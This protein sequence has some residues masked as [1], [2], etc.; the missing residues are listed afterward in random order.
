MT[1]AAAGFPLASAITR[2]E[3]SFAAH[4]ARFEVVAFT[5]KGINRRSQGDAFLVNAEHGLLAVADGVS[6]LPNG[7]LTA[8]RCLRWLNLALAAAKPLDAAAIR[9]SVEA[10]NRQ[11]FAATIRKQSVEL[12]GGCI[13]VGLTLWPDGD[14]L[15]YFHV[16]DGALLHR[17]AATGSF[18]AVTQPHVSPRRSA[19]DP[20][21]EV[22]RLAAAVGVRPTIAP[23]LGECE[24]G[25]GS[26]ILLASDGMSDPKALTTANWFDGDPDVDAF[27][28]H[29]RATTANTSDDMT[30]IAARRVD[31]RNTRAELAGA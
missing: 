27:E 25:P 13:L 14:G 18:D 9:R 2:S 5:A 22:S 23:D 15:T 28:A 21:R 19:L 6:T 7:D 11:I 10:V 3:W 31:G 1:S 24:L 12:L 17:R 29:V 26:A 16:G 8:R 20:N 30:I 4:D